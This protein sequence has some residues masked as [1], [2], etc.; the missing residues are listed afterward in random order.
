MVLDNKPTV[1][2]VLGVIYLAALVIVI[3]QYFSKLDFGWI[4]IMSLIVV[5][6]GAALFV[7]SVLAEIAG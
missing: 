1:L 2:P 5:I 6:A 7:L 4:G 3:F